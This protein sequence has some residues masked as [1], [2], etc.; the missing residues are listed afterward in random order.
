MQNFPHIPVLLDEAIE[1]LCVT[2]NNKYI[3]A[4]L[5]GGGHTQKILDMGGKVLGIDQDIDAINFCRNKFS[6]EISSGKLTIA[7]GNFANLKEISKGKKFVQV[8]GIL[9]DLGLSSYQLDESKRGFSIR[10]DEPLDMRMDKELM[11]N[12]YDVV[13]KYP[14]EKLTEIFYKYGEEHNAIKIAD[15]IYETRKKNPIKTT[16]E[17]ANLI[18]RIPHKSEPIHPATRVFQALRIDVNDEMNSLKKALT[19]GFELLNSKGRFAVI[20]FHSLEDRII[21][22]SFEKIQKEG[23]GIIVTKK[24]IATSFTESKKNRRARSA[25]LRIVEKI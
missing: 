3:D 16:K 18:E 4:T 14:K 6:Q 2:T 17:L 7:K 5:G 21:K 10:H 9:L 24:P 23:L 25:K 15:L 22:Q 19:E 20:S 13:N 11:L 8:D 1:G 12:A